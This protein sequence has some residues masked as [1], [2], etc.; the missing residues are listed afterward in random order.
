[1]ASMKKAMKF[2]F[3]VWRDLSTDKASQLKISAKGR[4]NEEED[5]DDV[6]EVDIGV[7]QQGTLLDIFCVT[8]FYLLHPHFNT[9]LLSLIIR[10]IGGDFDRTVAVLTKHEVRR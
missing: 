1:M 7:L 3:E 8:P 4:M 9:Y 5:E 2:P 6:H 10:L